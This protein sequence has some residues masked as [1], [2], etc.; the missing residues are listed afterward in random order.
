[1]FL[2]DVV[3]TFPFRWVFLTADEDTDKNQLLFLLKL[4]RLPKLQILLDTKE[5][6]NVVKKIFHM[7]LVKLT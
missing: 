7:R 1:M 2:F 5:A 6:H 4:L 3:A